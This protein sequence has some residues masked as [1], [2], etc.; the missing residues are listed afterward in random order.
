MSALPADRSATIPSQDETH[1][2]IHELLSD[3]TT[4]VLEE[5]PGLVAFHDHRPQRDRS[6]GDSWRG[7]QTLCH[8]SALLVSTAPP[9]GSPASTASL[10][11]AAHAIAESWGMHRRSEHE[12]H[13]ITEASWVDAAGGLLEIVV[14]VRVAVRAVSAPF[15][16]GSLAPMATTSPA[17]A[18]SPLTP[19]PR[20]VR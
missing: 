17:S 8:V 20:L 9:A 10:L 15:L 13:G 5:Q 19:P 4:T 7:L 18:L 11:E 6:S 2:R 1:H 14:G 12:G 3:L 16:P